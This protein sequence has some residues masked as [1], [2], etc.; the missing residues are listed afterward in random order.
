[1]VLFIGKRNCFSF[2]ETK[3]KMRG[4]ASNYCENEV[5]VTGG[6]VRPGVDPV[7][8]QDLR[9]PKHIKSQ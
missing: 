9:L 6:A 8:L 7:Y 3:E 4:D 1:M 5:F 2:I